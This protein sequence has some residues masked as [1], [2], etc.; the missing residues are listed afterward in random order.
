M[1]YTCDA[2]I[3]VRSCAA[4]YIEALFFHNGFGRATCKGNAR[5]PETFVPGI[6]PVDRSRAPNCRRDSFSAES[7]HPL[8]FDESLGRGFIEELP[9][10]IVG[11]IAIGVKEHGL[12]V[13]RPVGRFVIKIVERKPSRGS[14]HFT[15]LLQVSDVYIALRVAFEKNQAFSVGSDAE[16]R[17][18]GIFPLREMCE[19]RPRPARS[20]DPPG[21]PRD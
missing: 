21:L 13:R 7:F 12:A 2:T 6:F 1:Q 14:E 5:D 11:S 19:C 20:S 16:I 4:K 15:V 18:P 3:G 9:K 8:V 10:D 17:D